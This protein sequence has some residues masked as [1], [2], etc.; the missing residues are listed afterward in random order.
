MLIPGG[1]VCRARMGVSIP[2]RRMEFLGPSPS[3]SAAREAGLVCGGMLHG[4]MPRALQWAARLSPG[5]RGQGPSSFIMRPCLVLADSLGPWPGRNRTGGATVMGHRFLLHLPPGSRRYCITSVSI[6]G[7]LW[8][9]WSSS[10]PPLSCPRDPGSNPSPT[11]GQLCD[12]RQ[13][14]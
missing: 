5:G 3:L 13:L 12:C 7:S 2:T 6:L 10:L 14:A 4:G 11:A 1:K 8:P 9:S